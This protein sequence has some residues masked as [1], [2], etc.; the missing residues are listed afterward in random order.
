MQWNIYAVK[1]YSAIKKEILPFATILMDLEDI[2]LSE[3][4]QMENNKY[5]IIAYICNIYINLKKQTSK[6]TNKTKPRL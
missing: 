5:H 1:Y 3:V 4:T 2:M 6:T